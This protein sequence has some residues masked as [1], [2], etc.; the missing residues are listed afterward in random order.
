MYVCTQVHKLRTEYHIYM[1]KNGSI[2]M[3]GV[4][5]KNVSMPLFLFFSFFL[6]KH[7]HTHTQ[8]RALA[9]SRSLART[10]SRARSCTAPRQR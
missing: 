10:I 2:S 8:T 7:A 3:A 1:S 9:Q 6:L 5:S 4:T